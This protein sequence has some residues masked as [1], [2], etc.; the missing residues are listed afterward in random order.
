VPLGKR[1]YPPQGRAHPPAPA[2]K[3]GGLGAAAG[4]A[5]GYQLGRQVLEK[6][7]ELVRLAHHQRSITDANRRGLRPGTVQGG[8]TV[9]ASRPVAIVG[10]NDNRRG[11]HLQN[12]SATAT[13]SLGLGNTWP[14]IDTGITLGPGSSWDGL[15]SNM[16]WPGSVYA[17]GSATGVPYS[18]LES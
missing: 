4:L 8:G 14:L 15:V 17:I 1:Q 16:I 5:Q 18:W 6:L 11:F 12:L 13:I 10:H 2:I 9:S 7:D 3:G